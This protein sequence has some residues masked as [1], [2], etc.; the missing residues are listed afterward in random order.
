[1]QKKQKIA[2]GRDQ[3]SFGRGM[4]IWRLDGFYSIRHDQINGLKDSG[5]PCASELIAQYM[6][7]A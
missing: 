7:A 1:M 3:L 2:R 6:I 4:Y 5:F